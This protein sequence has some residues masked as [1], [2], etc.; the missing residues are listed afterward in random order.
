[1]KLFPKLSA[2]ALLGTALASQINIGGSTYNTGPF[3]DFSK[4]SN[5]N[6][7]GPIPNDDT[8]VFIPWEQFQTVT[9][10]KIRM[11]KEY[12]SPTTGDFGRKISLISQLDSETGL[13]RTF[14]GF[15]VTINGTASTGYSTGKLQPMGT[16]I[17]GKGKMKQVKCQKTTDTIR[18]RGNE[19][20]DFMLANIRWS[21]ST[22]DCYRG[23]NNNLPDI[24][25]QVFMAPNLDKLSFFGGKIGFLE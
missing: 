9:N 23:D 13:K 1:M 21:S 12:N 18:N 3:S 14:Q 11:A 15:L 20:L 5:N 8:V 22:N 6:G 19:K 24:T 4:C 16:N 2:T 25:F 10:Y 7:N 17:E